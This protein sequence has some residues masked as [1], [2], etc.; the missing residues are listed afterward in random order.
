MTRFQHD[1]LIIGSGAAG[2]TAA[3]HLAP[4]ARIGV[5]S[6]GPL[7]AANTYYAQGG[8]AAVLDE[9]DSVQAHIED[10]LIA[11]AG[12]CHEDAV[13]MTVENGPDAIRWLIGQGVGFTTEEQDNGQ[14]EYHLTRE[15]GHSHRRVIHAADATGF[16]ISSTLIEQVRKQAN[17]A[18]FESRVAVDVIT[19]QKLGLPGNRAL[20]AY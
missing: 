7:T 18:L 3:L 5:L 1:I 14:T 6:K 10:T 11:G 12:L 8:V 9:G 19:T 2:L 4:F 17:V 13:R 16:A 15:G 20:G